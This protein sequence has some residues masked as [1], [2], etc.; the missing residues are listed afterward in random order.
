MA[1]VGFMLVEGSE[2][3]IQNGVT[4]KRGLDYNIDYFSGTMSEFR[5]YKKALTDQEVQGLFLMPSAPSGRTT[6][7]GDRIRTGN[8]QSNNWQDG[9][10][11][12][13]KI[14]LNEG[15]IRAK[16]GEGW[17]LQTSLGMF[18]FSVA[19]MPAAGGG[20][21]YAQSDEPSP[22]GGG[23]GGSGGGSYYP[24]NDSPM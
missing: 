8:L 22:H 16:G 14:D 7:E 9:G 1:V 12:G 19:G 6:I 20:M 24:Q 5:I 2:E 10:I 23:S 13:T 3:V 4:L 11:E 15:E 18:D 17:K 21:D